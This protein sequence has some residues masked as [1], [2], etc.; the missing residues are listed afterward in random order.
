TVIL[1]VLREGLVEDRA[2][3]QFVRGSAH[4]FAQASVYTEKLSGG[5]NFHDAASCMLIRDGK[6]LVLLPQQLVG[7]NTLRDIDGQTPRV[8]EFAIPSPRIGG[9]EDMPNRAIFRSQTSRIMLD[10]FPSAQAL[11]NVLDSFLV[12]V[13]VADIAAD[14]FLG[15]YA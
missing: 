12:G 5:I 1:H 8:D 2:A 11:E 15:R 13:E 6:P 9:D 14:I 10:L 4:Q 3:E 7:A